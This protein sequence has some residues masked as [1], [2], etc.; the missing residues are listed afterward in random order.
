MTAEKYIRSRA[1]VLYNTWGKEIRNINGDI[2]F[3]SST[4]SH[5]PDEFPDLP[6]VPLPWVD[7]SYPPQKKSFLMLQFMWQHYGDKFEWF[8][9]ADDD[10]FIRTNLLKKFLSSLDSRKPLYIGQAGKGNPAESGLLSLEYDE[11][12]CMGGPGV[13]LSRKTVEIVAPFI[14]RCLKE[15]LTEHE[16]VEIGRCVRKYAGVPCTWS[17]EVNRVI[18][19]SIYKKKFFQHPL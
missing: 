8:I 12:F 15:L 7:D 19:N 13:I 4:H 17:Y 14:E 18:K 11:N 5:V 3:F 6:L 10:V 2:A 9:R 1:L 16:D